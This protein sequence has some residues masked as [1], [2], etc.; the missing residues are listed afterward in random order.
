MK[1]G[2]YGCGNMGSALLKSVL[3]QNLCQPEEVLVVERDEQKLKEKKETLR[4]NISTNPSDLKDCEY[5]I[6]AFKPQNLSSITPLSSDLPI[7]VSLLAGS[8]THSI[9]N[10][11]KSKKVIRTMPNLPIQ[12]GSGV[13]GLFFPETGLTTAEKNFVTAIFHSGGQ[14]IPLKQESDFD[15]FTPLCGS[16]PAYFFYLAEQLVRVAMG[17]GYDEHSANTMI[18]QVL[19]G[20]ADLVKHADFP[21]ET[22]RQQITSP[23]GVTEAAV[24]VLEQDGRISALLN[25][26][27]KSG[28]ERSRSLSS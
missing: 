15:S 17:N 10:V 27:I 1:L 20:A 14:V 2:F 4:V 28:I 24:S 7:L 3:K 21:L 25:E 12:Y 11:F 22:L 26:A 9:E 6:L 18:R 23:G 13:T 19:M 8:T 5:V 16:S